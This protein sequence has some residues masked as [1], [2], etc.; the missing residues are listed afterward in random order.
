MITYAILCP[1]SVY[2]ANEIV[3]AKDRNKGQAIIG[4]T[5]TAGG[6]L[7]SFIGG[8]LFQL[9]SISNVVLVGTIV[10]T[11]GSVLLVIGVLQLKKK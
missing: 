4:I 2:L 6:L 1:G 7:S 9:T 10:S 3:S 5:A 8:Q 11:I